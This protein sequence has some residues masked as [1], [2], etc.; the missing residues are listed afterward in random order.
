MLFRFCRLGDGRPFQADAGRHFSP[1]QKAARACSF[2]GPG[3]VR[4]STSV[5][6]A[7]GAL[8][9]SS[10]QICFAALAVLPPLQQKR[11]AI[12][13]PFHSS[14]RPVRKLFSGGAMQPAQ[15]GVTSSTR[16]QSS[17]LNS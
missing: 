13:F 5:S 16:S 12:F 2:S 14:R 4:G 1:S 11:A 8:S 17:E 9:P 10:S 6:A 7:S 15:I 3:F